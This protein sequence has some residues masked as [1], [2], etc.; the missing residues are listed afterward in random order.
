MEKPII[1]I[2][3]PQAQDFVDKLDDKVR[4]KLFSIIRKTKDRIVGQ[5]FI[6]LKS[7]NE[8]YEFR[9][10]ELGRFYRLFAF[11]DNEGENETLIVSTHG[12]I[13][14]TNKTLREEIN[15]AEKT[16]KRYFDNKILKIKQE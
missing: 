7:S 11:W 6:K 16:R 8:I 5:W 4:K 13:K 1:V 14:K 3:L 15:K 9:F 2:F 10:D 12:I